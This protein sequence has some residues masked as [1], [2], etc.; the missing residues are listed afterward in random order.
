MR[1]DARC[2]V[3]IVVAMTH[4]GE[5]K[6]LRVQLVIAIV[7]VVSVSL[8]L[9]CG[10]RVRQRRVAIANAIF[11][12]LSSAN[13]GR[14]YRQTC[15][16]TCAKRHEA[17]S[18]SHHIK[19][20]FARHPGMGQVWRNR[21]YVL[22]VKSRYVVCT[23]EDMGT[24]FTE[25]DYSQGIDKEMDRTLSV[26]PCHTRRKRSGTSTHD[27]RGNRYTGGTTHERQTQNHL[28]EPVAQR[29]EAAS[30]PYT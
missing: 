25:Y 20:E 22:V 13:R 26:A 27:T 1:T 29:P 3:R 17:R 4:H 30:T 8:R 9:S 12:T 28:S 2:H 11:V 15:V 10:R 5:D 23:P 19:L 7:I 18:E 21:I 14:I 16:G 24:T 6:G